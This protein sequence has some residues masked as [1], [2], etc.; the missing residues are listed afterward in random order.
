MAHGLLG[1]SRRDLADTGVPLSLSRGWLYWLVPV[2][3][4]AAMLLYF[5]ALQS[6]LAGELTTSQSRQI[7]HM[8]DA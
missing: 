2:L 8:R 3:A 5:L 4:A 7:I 1:N 6:T